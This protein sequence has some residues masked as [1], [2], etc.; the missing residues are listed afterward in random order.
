MLYGAL[1]FEGEISEQFKGCLSS[2]C[3]GA[4]QPCCAL[5]DPSLCFSADCLL[6][7]WGSSCLFTELT[8][9]LGTII[10]THVTFSNAG[11]LLSCVVFIN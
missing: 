3:S 9:C 11:D 4:P 8:G 6:L 10:H 2:Q 5:L 7:L 1:H